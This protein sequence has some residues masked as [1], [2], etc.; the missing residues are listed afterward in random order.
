MASLSLAPEFAGWNCGATDGPD[1][2]QLHHLKV[3]VV[4]P[5]IGDRDVASMCSGG[6]LDGDD[7]LIIWD[8]ALLPSEWNVEPMKYS[9]PYLP[10]LGDQ[11]DVDDLTTFFVT[12]MKNDNLASI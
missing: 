7:F 8:Q 11:I 2:P 12:Y 9:G 3:V 1:V 5:Q 6:D 4:L 10:K